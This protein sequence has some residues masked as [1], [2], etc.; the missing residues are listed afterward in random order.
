MRYLPLSEKNFESTRKMMDAVTVH[1][2]SG[3]LHLMRLVNMFLFGSRTHAGV[4]VAA[5]LAVA[6]APQVPVREEPIASVGPASTAPVEPVA[7][8]PVAA[9]ERD[10]HPVQTAARLATSAVEF[11]ESGNEE[12]ANLVLKQAI[13]L[14]PTNKLAISLARQMSEDPVA[15]FGRESFRYVVKSG[16]TLSRIAGQFLGDIYLFHALS[17]YNNIKIPKQVGAGQTIRIP[18]KSP[19]PM[20]IA[21]PAKGRGATTAEAAVETP[22]EKAFQAGQAAEK[23]AN[24]VKAFESYKAASDLGHAAAPGKLESV[25]KKM[26]EL[27]SRSA[28]TALARQNLDAAITEWDKVL[29]LKPGD[30]NAQL[31]RQKVLRLKEALQK[32]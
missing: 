9:V 5:L 7:V 25:K 27:Y 8:E 22:A 6:C 10:P 28:R 1:A 17:K 30:E 20:A 2:L 24:F 4:I 21:V 16:D 29:Q 32:K 14:D 15:R 18:G 3:T 12:Q 23:S 11:L 13:A 31:E 19:P 26:I